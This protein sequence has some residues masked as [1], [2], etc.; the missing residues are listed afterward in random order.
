MKS[1]AMVKLSFVRVFTSNAETALAREVR[2]G[3]RTCMPLLAYA[4]LVGN[5]ASTDAPETCK[6][7]RGFRRA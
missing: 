1:E 7:D 5:L 2:R 3:R 4:R 6:E